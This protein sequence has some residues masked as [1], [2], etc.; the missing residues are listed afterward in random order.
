VVSRVVRAK[1][2][3][4][5]ARQQAGKPDA[6]VICSWMRFGFVYYYYYYF[7][8]DG[9]DVSQQLLLLSFCC[10]PQNH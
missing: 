7:G 10:R 5:F 2:V 6:A 1:T 4:Q 9:E 3:E 8:R